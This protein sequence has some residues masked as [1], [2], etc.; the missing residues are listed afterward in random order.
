MTLENGSIS[1]EEMR[2]D[3]FEKSWQACQNGDIIQIRQ[4]YCQLDSSEVEEL[5]QRAISRSFLGPARVLLE[6]GAS[7]DS[8]LLNSAV[9]QCPVELLQLLSD[10]GAEFKT[11]EE[12]LLM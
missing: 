6:Q 4:L 10:F 11:T 9:E 5:L 12:N 1:G 3:V 7:L 2:K 8:I